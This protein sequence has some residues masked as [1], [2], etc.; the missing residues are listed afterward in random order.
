[1]FLNNLAHGL[2]NP[3][4]AVS[5]LDSSTTDNWP[6]TTIGPILHPTLHPSGIINQEFI[7]S[8]H[9]MP[10]AASLAQLKAHLCMREQ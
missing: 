3:G 10:S 2:V 8:L 9:K 6:T 5:N 7:N 4:E 1:M